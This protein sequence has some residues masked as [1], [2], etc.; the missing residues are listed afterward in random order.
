[1]ARHF[2]TARKQRRLRPFQRS[3][4]RNH[5][6]LSVDRRFPPFEAQRACS[7]HGETSGKYRL[8]KRKIVKV[9]TC[10]DDVQRLRPFQRSSSR[11]DRSLSVD[12]RFPPFKAQRARSTNGDASGKYRLVKRKIIKVITCND[13][14]N[15]FRLIWTKCMVRLVNHQSTQI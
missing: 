8:R 6:S 14:L 7:T 11:N 15:R 10:Y 2:C 13:A 3:S 12:G 4:S 1:M 5:R 9:I